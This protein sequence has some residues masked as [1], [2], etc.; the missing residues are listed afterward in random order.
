[1]WRVERLF[2]VAERRDERGKRRGRGVQKG[3]GLSPMAYARLKA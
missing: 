3:S 1:M 2:W